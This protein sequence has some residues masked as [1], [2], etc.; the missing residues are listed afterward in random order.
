MR[1]REP[2][3]MPQAVSACM[4]SVRGPKA[5]EPPLA[6]RSSC[7]LGRYGAPAALSDS[8]HRQQ[9]GKH[10]DGRDQHAS[11]ATASAP[12]GLGQVGG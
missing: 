7:R 9:P 4:R 12:V 10:L 8:G 1:T 11:A 5:T 2:E 6:G 3:S